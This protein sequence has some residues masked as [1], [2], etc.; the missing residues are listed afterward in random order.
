MQTTEDACL[1]LVA[2]SQLSHSHI[3]HRNKHR[4]S[5]TNILIYIKDMHAYINAYTNRVMICYWLI[6]WQL[7]EVLV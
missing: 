7:V 2:S 6:T 3:L 4:I 1:Q 5:L